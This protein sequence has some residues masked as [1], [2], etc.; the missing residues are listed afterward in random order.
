MKDN[1]IIIYGDYL[2]SSE[3]TSNI[4][5]I[6]QGVISSNITVN[7]K[8]E[9][10]LDGKAGKLKINCFGKFFYK[11]E[12]EESGIP[13]NTIEFFNFE[14]KDKKSFL[15]RTVTICINIKPIILLNRTIP[16]QV[17]VRLST[18]IN[19]NKKT[20]DCGVH[21]RYSELD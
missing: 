4:I 20:G 21:W 2:I 19:S 8:E 11:S 7:N 13:F 18:T 6:S 14:I 17:S 15:V 9:I 3:L 10:L 12:E 1:H 5:N 16:A